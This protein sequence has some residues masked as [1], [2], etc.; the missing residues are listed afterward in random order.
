MKS[1]KDFR[2]DHNVGDTLKKAVKLEPIRK[3]GKEKHIIYKGL[4]S[5]DADD[6]MDYNSLRKR[7][8]VLDYMDD[9]QDEQFDSDD[10]LEDE[11]NEDFDE[12]DDLDEEDDSDE[13]YDDDDDFEDEV[14]K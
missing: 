5:D 2:A 6:D 3:S 4:S 12:Q 14:V 1:I 9:E 7:E 8:S 11:N 13:Q 10:E